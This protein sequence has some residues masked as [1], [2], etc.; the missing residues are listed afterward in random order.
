MPQQ[1]VFAVRFGW[2][3]R[4]LA[5]LAP[6]SD[7]VVLVDVLRFTTAVSVAVSRGAVVLPYGWR[8]GRAAGFAADHGAVLA[9]CLRNAPAVGRLLATEVAAGRTVAVIASGERWPDASGVAHAGPLR[10][11]VEDLLGA[12]AVLRH[13]GDLTRAQLSPE[14]RAARA[15]FDAAAPTLHDELREAAS[16]REL[17]A[18]GWDDDVAAAAAL[19]ADITVPLLRD[20][21]FHA[22]TAMA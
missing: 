15:A 3:E 17:L 16:G 1:R 10:P 12:G 14:A 5:V 2:G 9:G 21:A 22:M 7:L 18:L 8:D 6:V 11:A 20:G 13:L 4:D 19:G